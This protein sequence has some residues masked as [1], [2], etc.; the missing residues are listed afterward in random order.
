MMQANISF[1][2]TDRI[3]ITGTLRMPS[4]PSQAQDHIHPEPRHGRPR[5]RAQ[6]GEDR[7][8]PGQA[9][10]EEVHPAQRVPAGVQGGDP[11]APPRARPLLV[12]ARA[13]LAR[14]A[15]PRRGRW[16]PRRRAPERSPRGRAVRGDRRC[17]GTRRAADR[18]ARGRRS[19]IRAG[20][21][22][23]PGCRAVAGAQSG[24][25]ARGGGVPG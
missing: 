6:R 22:G 24:G 2:F 3:E 13:R 23:P 1:F 18:V 8:Q 4:N 14:G 12:P 21:P 10:V 5:D 16:G 25:A 17:R 19:A 20:S 7:G 15:L 9:R 11:R